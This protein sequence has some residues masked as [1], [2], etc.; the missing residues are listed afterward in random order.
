MSRNFELLA[1]IESEI[2]VAV[3]SGSSRADHVS[4]KAIASPETVETAGNDE[5]L[6]LVQRVFLTSTGVAPHQVVF[7]GV[8]RENGSSSVCA[9]AGRSLAANTSHQVCLVD[10]N[11]KSP[12]LS[13]L[14]GVPAMPG[15]SRSS[16]MREQCVQIG[17]NLW[18][19]GS[20]VLAA[21]SDTLPS[22]NE[23]RLR[24]AQ[25]HHEFEYILID[26]PGTTVNGDAPLLGQIT[27][28]AILVIEADCTRRLTASK[29]KQSLDAAGVRLLG[30]V[31]HNRSFPIPKSIYDR[32]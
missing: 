12:R 19:A 17:D 29:A 8:E 1:Q 10:A 9:R 3:E 27:D 31:L 24:L 2:G 22:I 21:A 23:L 25:L 13:A 20:H 30:T 4:G 14:F 7:C 16:S 6:Q 11:L 5:I 32:L 28:A 18:V 15:I 26:A